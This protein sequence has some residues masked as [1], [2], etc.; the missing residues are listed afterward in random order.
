MWTTNAWCEWICDHFLQEITKNQWHEFFV[1]FMILRKKYKLWLMVCCHDFI[2]ICQSFLFLFI[3]TACMF[4]DCVHPKITSNLVFLKEKNAWSATYCCH[5]KWL[6]K[7]VCFPNVATVY[8]MSIFSFYEKH[9][10]HAYS[11]I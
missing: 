1:R 7:Y 5:Q 9:T 11:P 2:D 4:Y 8:L 3:V 6:R 10:F